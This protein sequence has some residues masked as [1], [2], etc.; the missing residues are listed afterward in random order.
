MKSER[1]KSRRDKWQIQENPVAG[2][3]K[4]LQERS[5]CNPISYSMILKGHIS[6]FFG[7]LYH[8]MWLT[9]IVFFFQ[10]SPCLC[11]FECIIYEKT[12]EKV[13][14]RE[15]HDPKEGRLQTYPSH[16]VHAK[17]NWF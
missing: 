10:I 1:Y 13:S 11:L 14:L 8:L 6:T 16:Q 5:R 17:L 3:V 9:A 15:S 7:I 4:E 2:D 12:E